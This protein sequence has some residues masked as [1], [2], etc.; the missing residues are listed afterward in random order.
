M[1]YIGKLKQMHLSL[2][3][4][5]KVHININVYICDSK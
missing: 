1:I 2:T 4:I 3:A 5:S